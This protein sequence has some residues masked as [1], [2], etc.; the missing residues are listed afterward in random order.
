MDNRDVFGINPVPNNDVLI[1]CDHANDD[2]K[3]FKL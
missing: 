3:G 1:I 2:I